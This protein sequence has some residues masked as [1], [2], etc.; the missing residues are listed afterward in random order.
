MRGEGR[1]IPRIHREEGAQRALASSARVSV[2]KMGLENVIFVKIL[3]VWDLINY[4]H[5]VALTA[6]RALRVVL[7]SVIF[8]IL[9]TA[10]LQPI[11]P[12][13]NVDQTV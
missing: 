11:K 12:V 6:S 7:V 4:A 10:S 2:M 3:S 8:V 1:D 9:A 5:L 13:S